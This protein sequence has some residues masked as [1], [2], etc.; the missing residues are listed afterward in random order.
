MQGI[1]F[2]NLVMLSLVTLCCHYICPR[3]LGFLETFFGFIKLKKGK[4]NG[5]LPCIFSLQIDSQMETSCLR[6][7]EYVDER[8]LVSCKSLSCIQFITLPI[9][10]Y[11]R[12]SSVQS[13]EQWISMYF[14]RFFF[15]TRNCE[16]SADL[17]F[18]FGLLHIFS[19]SMVTTRRFQ[20]RIF[21]HVKS[22]EFQ[23][24]LKLWTAQNHWIVI[25]SSPRLSFYLVSF[26]K[27][28]EKTIRVS[29]TQLK[30]IVF[31]GLKGLKERSSN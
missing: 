27:F 3:Y 5:H 6:S 28:Y 20:T 22:W 29:G 14:L 12:A 17:W 2:S 23:L 25:I 8:E 13:L 19:S 30:D 24:V 31:K 18:S 21:Y 15:T 16:Y 1:Q 10:V 9:R 11:I 4:I 7:F 26:Q